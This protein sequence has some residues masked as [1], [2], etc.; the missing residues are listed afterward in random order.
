MLCLG[1]SATRTHDCR[2]VRVCRS[3]GDSCLIGHP[4]DVR[5]WCWPVVL[6]ALVIVLALVN[7][8]V[9][10]WLT[11]ERS[12]VSRID[13][14]CPLPG[15]DSNY[16]GSEWR[17]VPPARVCVLDGATFDEPSRLRVVAVVAFPVLLCSGFVAFVVATRRAA[18]GVGVKAA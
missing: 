5:R 10:G 16:T 7:L 1:P 14:S 3:V 12:Q 18:K 4:G 2:S 13:L 11:Y 8:G 9:F 17:W 6:L 15:A